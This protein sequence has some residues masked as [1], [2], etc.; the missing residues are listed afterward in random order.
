MRNRLLCDKM[1]DTTKKSTKGILELV[2]QTWRTPYAV[3]N[4][5]IIQK[6]FSFLETSSTDGI[7]TK[8]VYHWKQG[9][10]RNAVLDALAMN[11][12]DLLLMRA[13]AYKL[14][15]HIIIPK[16][17]ERAILDIIESFVVECKKRDI[18]ITGGETSIH[19]NIN[20]IDIS[21]TVDGFIK[22]FRPNIFDVGSVLIGLKSNGFHS[23][24]FTKIRE[25]FKE[26]FRPEFV[27][28]TRIYAD[29][30]LNLNE[31]FDIHGM[32]HITGGAFTKLKNLLLD[33]DVVI[34][35]NHLLKPQE[36][37]YEIYRRG[38]SDEEMYKTF[39]CG[40]GFVLGVSNSDAQSIV[41]ELNGLGLKSDII[42]EVVSGD[43]NVRIKS[44]FSDREVLL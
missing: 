37:F 12:N 6:N 15:N 27:E 7:G 24:G 41:S 43:G 16:D 4:E 26:E 3:V 40:V 29:E 32:M 11:L 5:G 20:G 14:Q 21:V 36:I 31:K 8:G 18:A 23:N 28:P 38:I 10:F 17:D 9:T 25:I 2:K 33:N 22:K 44:M 34:I 19:D 35:N 13:R 1:Y 39:N 42:G 30:I